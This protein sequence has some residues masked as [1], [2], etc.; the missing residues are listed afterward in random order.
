MLITPAITALLLYTSA[1]FAAPVAHD[2]KDLSRRQSTNDVHVSHPHSTIPLRNST[3]YTNTTKPET[4]LPAIW[5][6]NIPVPLPPILLAHIKVKGC[7]LWDCGRTWWN[8]RSD[9]WP[10]PATY[11]HNP[12]N[13][14]GVAHSKVKGCGLWKSC[15]DARSLAVRARQEGADID[16][17]DDADRRGKGRGRATMHRP[18]W[19]L[20]GGG[21]HTRSVKGAE[22]FEAPDE[23]AHT[24]KKAGGLWKGLGGFDW[25]QRRDV[26]E[27]EDFEVP[28]SESAHTKKKAESLW[29][30]FR[31]TC[32]RQN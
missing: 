10:L 3:G 22:D 30:G 13:S 5:L 19:S 2:V 11:T 7:G 21:K 9:S 23:S 8:K 31:N 24:K 12:W 26:K 1:S 4:S 25:W 16:D 29:E 20:W 27:A 6:G 18:A 14:T 17:V 32:A 15:A 28:D